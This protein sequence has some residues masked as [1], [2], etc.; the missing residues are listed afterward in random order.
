MFKTI[1][2]DRALFGFSIHLALFVVVVGAL[3]AL[4]LWRNPDRIWF[5]W[6][7]A[8][9]GIGLAAHGLA[10]LLKR[11][12]RRER[13]FL[14]EKARGFVVHLFVYVTVVLLLFA[15]N[16]LK[17]PNVWWFYWVALGW[18]AGVVVQAWCVFWKHRRKQ[19]ALAARPQAKQGKRRVAIKRRARK[20]G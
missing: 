16:Y 7:L 2:K 14:D 17:T 11:T 15:V 13:I 19:S 18:G 6:V 9:W 1:S 8:G 3:A 12:R 4:N 5:V 20:R 10:L